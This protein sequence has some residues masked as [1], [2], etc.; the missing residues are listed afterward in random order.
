[1]AA[2]V[3]LS[4]ASRILV[5]DIVLTESK[6]S[7]RCRA[8]ARSIDAQT[9]ASRR[10]PPVCARIG[11]TNAEEFGEGKTVVTTRRSALL[12]V[13]FML[14]SISGD[15]RADGEV[16]PFSLERYDDDKEGFT[17]LRPAAWNKVGKA[18]ATL[19]FEDPMI[20]SNTVGVV[21]NP[22]RIASLKD[23]GTPEEVAERLIRAEKK[24]PSTNDAK[25]VRVSERDAN[26][27][28]LYEVE[29]N[30]DSSRGQK[31]VISAVTIAFRKL[32]ILNVSYSDSPSKPISQDVADSL[33]RIVGSFNLL[34]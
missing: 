9:C 3:V 19:L 22:V 21:V 18:G 2:G 5:H 6:F 14:T 15:V 20:K 26:G 28:P 17:V 8:R 10:T 12:L 7:A 33:E 29:Y 34:R 4:S 31:R 24:K 23:F 25:L 1:M 32:Y 30:L 13:G 16:E 11:T 27:R